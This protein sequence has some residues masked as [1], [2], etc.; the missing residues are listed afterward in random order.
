MDDGMD[1]LEQR[2]AERTAAL[3]TEIVQRQRAEEALRESEER[4][5]LA[6][7]ASGLGVWDWNVTTSCVFFS[8]RLTEA[9]GYSETEF[10]NT[11]DAWKQR[12]HPD[13]KSAV[14][15]KLERHFAGEL[16][17]YESEHRVQCKD[18]AYVWVLDRGMII[19]RTE[20][21]KPVRMI[22]THTDINERRQMADDLRRQAEELADA[23]VALANAAQ[24]KDEFLASMSHELRTPLAGILGLTETL[25]EEVY[26][27]LNDRQQNAL[28]NIDSS[29]H[30]LLDL[31]NDILDIV[32]I[33]SG[34]L[35][36]NPSNVDLDALCEASV[37]LVVPMAR[38]KQ[39]RLSYTS[40]ILGANLWADERRVK[41]ILANLLTNAVKFTPNG[42]EMG[43][44]VDGD[45]ALKEIQFTVW[46]KGIGIAADD[47]ARIFLPFVQLDSRL[48]RLHAGTGL[49]LAL[50][51]RLAALHG[52]RVS[53]ESKPDQGSRF[54]V[55]LPW[56]DN[57]EVAMASAPPST[58]LG[59]GS[60]GGPKSILVIEDSPVAAQQLVHYLS[61][62]GITEVVVHTHVRD[63]LARVEATHPDFV[64]LDIYLPDGLGWDILAA[65]KLDPKTHAI[66]V[67]VVTVTDAQKMALQKG[68]DAY[69]LKPVTLNDLQVALVSAAGHARHVPFI[70]SV[71]KGA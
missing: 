26:G 47:V 53:V 49:G 21:G 29:G 15:D 32:K 48:A 6:L 35:E 51:H 19:E 45:A 36:L 68:A 40:H 42:G 18:G 31:I 33:A 71:S 46:D 63:A 69:L 23:N 56:V 20:E 12:I 16:P 37:R 13:D 1:E 60:H 14:M 44:V 50:I 11:L 4:W 59:A 62:L 39:Q 57:E 22:G 17:H 64:L 43:L 10:G 61:M 3:E 2:V 8:Q 38:A 58:V 24:M 70:D 5:N 9:L 34:N 41:Q 30:H 27:P 7:S 55:T 28:R 25:R 54:I 52:G 66:P 67:V 65:L